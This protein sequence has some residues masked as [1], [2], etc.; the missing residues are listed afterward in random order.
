MAQ[1]DFVH[2]L[3]DGRQ[4]GYCCY[5]EL[6][7]HA[8]V[9]L[10]GTPGSRYK[11]SVADSE[12]KRLG[13]R[14]ICP[15][16][17][18]YGLSDAPQRS[19]GLADYASDIESLLEVV[20]VERFSVV[21]V[22]GGGPYAAALAAVLGTRVARLALVAPVAPVDRADRRQG[23]SVFHRITFRGLP[24]L[25]GFIPLVFS[26]FRG[27]LAVS[28]SIALRAM[29]ARAGLADRV[30]LAE[31]EIAADLTKAFK[32]GLACGVQGPQIDMGLFSRDWKLDLS[33]VAS[34]SGMWLGSQDRNVPLAAARRLAADIPELDLI[35][36][37]N[38]GHFWITKNFGQVLAWI[39]NDAGG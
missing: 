16:R 25:P 23:V 38:S 17:W 14:L 7:G 4:L 13:L 9:A 8:V 37:E 6:D 5:G 19:A 18:G 1:L 31:P 21:G 27:L 12:A 24:R 33:G 29:S 28:P 36:V 32:T 11:F 35:E 26:C 34:R 15:D 22:S 3:P 20:G 30:L 39:A 2:E 10:H